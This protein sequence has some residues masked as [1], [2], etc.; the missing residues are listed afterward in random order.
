MFQNLKSIL[1]KYYRKISYHTSPSTIGVSSKKFI[2]RN[3]KFL[4]GGNSNSDKIFYVIQRHGG[5]GGLFSDLIFVIN[6]LKVAENYGFIPVVDME[7]FPRWYNE[8]KKIK[9][10][11]NSWN[12]YFEPLTQYSLDEIYKSQNVILTSSRFYS[13]IDFKY[14]IQDSEDLTKIYKKYIKIKKEIK[15][16]V[17]FFQKNFFENKKI[18]G[19]HFRGTSYKNGRNPYP[20]TIKQMINK[21]N[22]IK[23][24]DNYDKIFL[25]TEDIHHFNALKKEF[26]DDLIYLKES[27]RS[28]GQVAFE[29][30]PRLNH[31][32]KLGRDLLVETCLLSKCDGYL[33][34]HGNI[35]AAVLNMNMNQKQKRY[36]IDNGFNPGIPFVVNYIWYIKSLL[37]SFLGGFK[38]K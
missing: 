6:H 35:R 8:K 7:N 36:L 1:R 21:I 9:K 13:D 10:T 12:Y 19:V 24:V 18:L 37:P 33:D 2:G 20:A 11:L 4:V 31:R 22:E 25:V 34:T 38:S 26:N 28:T 17:E 23:K 32:Y 5:E 30:Y 16:I 29:T 27:F 14:Q 3:V 15:K